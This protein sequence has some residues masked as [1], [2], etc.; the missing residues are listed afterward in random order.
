MERPAVHRLDPQWR[1]DVPFQELVERLP[2]VIYAETIDGDPASLYISPRVE[3]VLGYTPEEWVATPRFWR[4]HIHPDDLERVLADNERA[5]ETLEP[6]STEYRFVHGDGRYRWVRDQATYVGARGD[7]DAHWQGYL[8]DISEQRKTADRL[9]EAERRYREIVER[10]P[11]VTYQESMT[12]DEWQSSIVYISPQIE[13]MMGYPAERWTEDPGF[14]HT[15]MHPDDLERVYA[16]AEPSIE[17]GFWRAEYRMFASDGR[18]VWVHDESVLISDGSRQLWQGFMADITEQRETAERLAEAERKYRSLVEQLPAV[19][20]TQ[21]VD[22][23]DSLSS[24]V[25]ISPQNEE[26]IGYTNDEVRRNP[27]LWREILHPDDRER[28]LAEDAASNVEGDE[29]SQE[30]RMI[31][32]DGHVL[33]I[34][35]EAR[36]IR[37]DDGNPLFWQGF[38]FDITEQREAHE[39]LRESHERTQMIVDTAHDALV[40]ADA[41]GAI[42]GWNPQAERTFGWTREEIVGRTLVDTIIPPQHRKAHRIGF[43]RHLE[44]GA[45]PLMNRRIEITALHRDGHEFPVELTLARLQT[46]GGVVFSAFIRDITERKQVQ[47]ELERALAVEREATNRLRA[48]DDM[49]NTFL[50]AVSHDL[51][52]PLAAI[53]GLSVTLERSEV[54][55]DPEE[56]RDLA[57]RISTNARKLDRLVRDLLDL[58]RLLRGIVEPKLSRTEISS[59][60]RRTIADSDLLAE[61]DVVVETDPVVVDVD[62]PKIE[63]IVE[64]LLANTTRHTPAGTTVWVKVRREPDGVLIAV[65]DDGPGVSPGERDQIFEAFRQGPDAPTHSPGVGVGLTLVARFAQLHRGRAWVEERDGGGASFRVFLPGTPSDAG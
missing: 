53:L 65:E 5:N 3:S 47:G 56:A 32:K 4:E 60:V 43:R 49:K 64:N 38:M 12:D 46:R 26:L 41:E 13:S 14:W 11:L 17:E 23:D 39:A 6:Y 8:V 20:Y 61:R 48:L 33:W 22:E 40:T 19:V 63:R 18:V 42:T 30:Y 24:T 9:A 34:R 21:V 27:N 58:D 2:A 25:F 50:Q 31:H 54:E 15:L 28:V 51:R 37:D 1:R 52:T 35:D 16:G 44:T 29:F 7:P 57:R 36:M 55:L 45:G 10:T 59:L 62:G